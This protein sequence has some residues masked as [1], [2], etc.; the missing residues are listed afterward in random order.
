MLRGSQPAHAAIRTVNGAAQAVFS[1]FLK[2]I[3]GVEMILVGA[4]AIKLIRNLRE[5][6][7]TS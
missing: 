3:C 1:L 4:A 6:A 7:I 5:T 2:P